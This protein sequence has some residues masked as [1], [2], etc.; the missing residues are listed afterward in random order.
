MEI[1]IQPSSGRHEGWRGGE[2]QA[3]REL[4]DPWLATSAG[5]PEEG[6]DCP[7]CY[8]LVA[9]PS[10]QLPG[11]TCATCNNSFHASCI[12]KWFST[13][14]AVESVGEVDQALPCPLCRSKF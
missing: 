3:L 14:H 11:V 7:I 8:S 12:F 13:Q 4:L 6:A 9:L 10:R 2:G 5:E 1:M